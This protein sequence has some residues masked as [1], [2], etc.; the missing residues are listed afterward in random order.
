MRK[1]QRLNFILTNELRVKGS[2]FEKR[3]LICIPLVTM[4]DGD[5]SDSSNTT[6]E[7]L[8]TDTIKDNL[9]SAAQESIASDDYLS[10]STIID[11]YLSDPNRFSIEERESVLGALLEV[12]TENPKLTYEIGWDLPDLLILYLDNN[13]DFLGPIREC[14]NLH[15]VMKIFE[16]LAQHGN[17]KELFLKSCEL[18]STMKISDIKSREEDLY[19]E[20][21]FDLRLYCVLELV[22]S[23]LKQISTAYPSRFLSMCLSSL[24]NLIYGNFTNYHSTLIEFVLKR[25]YSFMRNYDFAKLTEEGKKNLNLT[26]EELEKLSDDEDYLQRKLLVGFLSNSIVM[27]GKNWSP[28]NS[29]LYFQTFCNKQVNHDQNLFVLGRLYELNLSFDVELSKEFQSLIVSSHELFHKFKLGTKS[30]D[31]LLGDIFLSVVVDYQENLFISIIDKSG[32]EISLNKLGCLLY[33]THHINTEVLEDNTNFPVNISFND[34]LILTLRLLIPQMINN[35]FVNKSIQDALVFWNWY[36]IEMSNQQKKNLSLDI[37]SIPKVYLNIYFQGL[38]FICT[39]NPQLFFKDFRFTS[40]TLLT[41]ILISSP[42]SISY[43]FL[44]DALINCPF[45]NVRVALIGVL[46]E[47]LT[48]DKTLGGQPEDEVAKDLQDL[49]IEKKEKPALPARD[50]K[51]STKYLTLTDSR[52]NDIVGILNNTIS[53][54]FTEIPTS[55][56]GKTKS[57]N[58][59][60]D[61]TETEGETEGSGISKP[62]SPKKYTINHQFLPNLSTELNLMIVL[63]TL[64]GYKN[65]SQKLTPVLSRL[66]KVLESLKVQYKDSVNESNFLDMLLMTLDRFN[67]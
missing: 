42:E 19:K 1:I 44:K 47:L 5:F 57:G 64:D 26:R 27:L 40:L 9:K 14:P 39:S 63:K 46:K 29:V 7:N 3:L 18:L 17:P 23:N 6:I 12:L 35:S 33:Y 22:S 25:L 45:N 41:K 31:D 52:F 2:L 21:F 37:S 62:S 54:T 51:K 38:L 61:E 4:S 43:D 32:K 34:V 48:K 59:D 24:I 11:I 66:S 20:K 30:D 55:A 50:T 8:S 67:A 16:Q 10:Y 56:D 65:N 36:V 13:H 28:N 53:D 49:S 60:S 58:D 15:K